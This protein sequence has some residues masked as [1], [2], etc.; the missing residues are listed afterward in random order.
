MYRY[1]LREYFSQF[2]SLP[3][4]YLTISHPGVSLDAT[5]CHCRRAAT[6]GA[7]RAL[8]RDA[9]ARRGAGHRASFAL[10]LSHPL[11]FPRA[12]SAQTLP[13]R[14]H[15]MV[16]TALSSPPTPPQCI[17]QQ[18]FPRFDLGDRKTL[19]AVLERVGFFFFVL[20]YFFLASLSV[21]GIWREER[22]LFLR[23][24]DAR[25]YSAPAYLTSKFLCDTLLLRVVPPSLFASITYTAI[26]LRAGPH[27]ALTFTQLLVATNVGATAMFFAISILTPSVSSANLLCILVSLFNMLFCGALA[28]KESFAA[29]MK[30]LF[31]CAFFARL[32]PVFLWNLY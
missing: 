2:D 12:L 29:S 20:S 15:R 23:E 11:S 4:T 32:F 28:Q 16:L 8:R 18:A 26:D 31:R 13:P 19:N 5:Q 30:W 3:L 27:F 21:V 7:A 1:I 6:D 24:R 22:L 10:S 14:P 25:C 9:R 17:A